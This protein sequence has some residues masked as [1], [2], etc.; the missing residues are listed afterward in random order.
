MRTRKQSG[1]AGVP[2]GGAPGQQPGLNFGFGF[3]FGE[4]IDVEVE[5]LKD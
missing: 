5:A 3:G 4:V 1:P 2:G